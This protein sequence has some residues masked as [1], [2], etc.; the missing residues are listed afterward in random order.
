MSISRRAF[1]LSLPLAG[2]AT[3]GTTRGRIVEKRT[4][5][6]AGIAPPPVLLAR[7]GF[8]LVSV[9]RTRLGAEYTLAFASLEARAQAWDRFNTDPQWCA[10][11]EKSGVQL[12][13]ISLRT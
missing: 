3:A 9:K 11:L 8:D 12:L 1:V 4:Y 13:G 5:S 2:L 10:L 6:L 7:N